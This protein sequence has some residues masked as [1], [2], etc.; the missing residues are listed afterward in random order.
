MLTLVPAWIIIRNASALYLVV[1]VLRF[2]TFEQVTEN[3]SF[4]VFSQLCLLSALPAASKSW[5]EK[6]P[7]NG[8]EKKKNMILISMKNSLCFSYCDLISGYTCALCWYKKACTV[9]WVDS[10]LE[11]KWNGNSDSYDNLVK[12]ISLWC[13]ELNTNVKLSTYTKWQYTHS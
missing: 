12:C 4:L 13:S 11:W 8:A 9:L 10:V 1:C 5:Y 6:I 2:G 3:P 7:D